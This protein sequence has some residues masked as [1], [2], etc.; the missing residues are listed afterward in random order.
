MVGTDIL[1][2]GAHTVAHAESLPGNQ[3]ITGQQGLGV[4]TQVD[5]D[6][7][8]CHLLDRTGDQFPNAITVAVHDAHALG[9][10]H[11]L[12][13]DLLGGLGADTAKALGLD[14]LLVDIAWLQVGVDLL[15]FLQGQL[16]AQ[17]GDRIIVH[18][19]PAAK[20]FV[21]A[22]ATVDG[23]PDVGL[24]ILKTLF[25]RG[26]QCQLDGLENHVFLDAF[27]VGNGLNHHQDF[28]TH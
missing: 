5:D 3:L 15:R 9:F 20:G 24:F 27:F 21:L 4:V 13:D 19:Q 8:P 7:I 6:V 12:E 14:L 18:H 22:C 11:L 26:C 17:R 16:G 28:F 10:T 2:Q 1:Q 23:H 25:G